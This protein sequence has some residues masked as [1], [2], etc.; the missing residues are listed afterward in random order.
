MGL[1]QILLGG[2]WLIALSSNA[3]APDHDRARD[4]LAAGEILPLGT[5]L[6]RLERSHP[7]QILEVELERKGQ[8]WIYEIK[9]LRPGGGIGTL[10]IDAR[11]AT[12]IEAK[13]RAPRP[14]DEGRH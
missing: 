12:L 10:K 8:R 2:L 1:R 9:Q 7:G 5:V 3:D 13:E 4:A 14:T 11:D 6:A